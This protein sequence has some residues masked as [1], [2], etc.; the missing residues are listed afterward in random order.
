MKKSMI[1]S[2]SLMVALISF[3]AKAA[4][5]SPY[6]KVVFTYPHENGD[7][8]VNLEDMPD[9]DN[10]GGKGYVVIKHTHLNK[11]IMYSSL[12]TAIATGHKVRYYSKGCAGKNPVVSNMFLHTNVE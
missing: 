8:Y 4:Y 3:C 10:C 2:F 1:V 12:L 6:S 5:W 7:I 9:T 11:N